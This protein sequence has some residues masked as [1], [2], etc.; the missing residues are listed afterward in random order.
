VFDTLWPE[1]G[2]RHSVRFSVSHCCLLVCAVAVAAADDAAA[3]SLADQKRA[4]SALQAYVGSWRGVGQP[5]RGSTQGAWT[6]ELAWSWRFAPGRAMLVF[7]SPQGKFFTAGE[8]SPSSKRGQFRLIGT[9]PDGTR[10]AYSGRLTDERL[11]L[12]ADQHAPDRPAQI[13]LR[14]VA[15]GD[16]MLILYERALNENGQ[17]TRLAE[18]GFTRKGSGFGQGASYRECV[19]TGGLGT[20]SVEHQ[21][22]TWNVCCTGCRDLFTDDPAGVLADYRQRKAEEKQHGTRQGEQKQFNQ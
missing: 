13:T 5:K 20:I 7:S 19:V 11:V 17:F 1:S 15:D 14:Q 12:R 10:E 4:L 21:R 2:V 18:V 6:E 8:L 3:P 9:R 16:R 22:Q